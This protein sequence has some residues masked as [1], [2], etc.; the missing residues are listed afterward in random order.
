MQRNEGQ[1]DLSMEESIDGQCVV[2][3]VDVGKYLDTSLIKADIQPGHIR[4]VCHL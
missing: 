4:H 3:E 2:L 1:W